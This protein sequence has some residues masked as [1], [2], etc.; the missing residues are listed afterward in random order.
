MRYIKLGEAE[1]QQRFVVQ[2]YI[3]CYMNKVCLQRLL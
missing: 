3:S 2:I 1:R